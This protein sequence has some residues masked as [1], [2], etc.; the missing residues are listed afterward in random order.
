MFFYTCPEADIGLHTKVIQAVN[1]CAVHNFD[2]FGLMHKQHQEEE[3]ANGCRVDVPGVLGAGGDGQVRGFHAGEEGPEEVHVGLVSDGSGV[4]GGR[5]EAEA[6]MFTQRNIKG[7]ITSRE[8]M[9][10]FPRRYG[11]GYTCST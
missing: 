10:F 2:F 11:G 5:I 9:G 1:L 6:E 7:L 8:S 4:P 3:Y